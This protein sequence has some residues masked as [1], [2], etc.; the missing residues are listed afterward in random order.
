MESTCGWRPT[1]QET[2][3]TWERRTAKSD[4]QW[5]CSS[6]LWVLPFPGEGFQVE[7]DSLRRPEFP[8]RPPCL[9]LQGE[10]WKSLSLVRQ[11]TVNMAFKGVGFN[12]LRAW[13]CRL[14]F[15]IMC[16]FMMIPSVGFY[17]CVGGK[18]KGKCAWV[19]ASGGG[20][21]VG[22]GLSVGEVRLW[23]RPVGPTS[24]SCRRACMVEGIAGAWE[25]GWW[26]T[27]LVLA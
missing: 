6:D 9:N 5:V 20:V 8:R 13:L 7:S 12:G 25:W 19:F 3:V 16:H 18:G 14:N 11:L 21:C 17:L 23:E 1:S 27:C 26:N 2:C 22:G 24:G 4:L 15:G 10:V